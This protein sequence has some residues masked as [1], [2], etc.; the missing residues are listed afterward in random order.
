MLSKKELQGL[1][2]AEAISK[3][4]FHD[5]YAGKW[6]ACSAGA[7]P[8]DMILHEEDGI[9]KPVM[10]D[11]AGDGI[12][13]LMNLIEKMPRIPIAMIILSLMCY[14]QF[15]LARALLVILFSAIS[16]FN[17]SSRLKTAESFFYLRQGCTAIISSLR[18]VKL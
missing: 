12:E 10:F 5:I 1:T 2:D 4:A 8:E 7:G 15:I 11:D 9:W 18:S 3:I 14:I 13:Y 16:I 17:P 6:I